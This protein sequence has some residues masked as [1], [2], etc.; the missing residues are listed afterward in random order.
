MRH[1]KKR[2]KINFLSNDEEFYFEMIKWLLPFFRFQNSSQSEEK[3]TFLTFLS[4][5][6]SFF[7]WIYLNKILKFIFKILVKVKIFKTDT[8]DRQ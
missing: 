7:L 8:K 6:S 3:Q 2:Q 1:L 4:L 5:L